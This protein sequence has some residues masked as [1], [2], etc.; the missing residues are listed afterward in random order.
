M[1]FPE[2]SL[3][4]VV[5]QILDKAAGD[6]WA[7]RVCL[8][9]AATALDVH[10]DVDRV[11]FL[12]G[13]LQRLQDLQA[14]QFERIDFDRHAV[15]SHDAPPLR[16]RRPRD[17]GLSLPARDDRLHGDTS[18]FEPKSFEISPRLMNGPWGGLLATSTISRGLSLYAKRPPQG[19]FMSL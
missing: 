3:E 11:D 7:D 10:I 9:Q 19:P 14:T 1:V 2:E 6:R 18:N 5:I 15:D 17:R 16:Q 13:E 12:P 4:I 8:A